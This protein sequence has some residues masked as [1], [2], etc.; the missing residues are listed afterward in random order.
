MGN[1]NVVGIKSSQMIDILITKST[2]RRQHYEL[3]SGGEAGRKHQ[4]QNNDLLNSKS[5][6]TARQELTNQVRMSFKYNR[7]SI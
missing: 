7:A 1:L 2:A 4:R 5:K 3:E 6:N